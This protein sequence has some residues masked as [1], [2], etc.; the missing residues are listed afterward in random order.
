[1]G[2]GSMAS[3]KY[4]F[5]AVCSTGKNFVYKVYDP[6]SNRI[7]KLVDHELDPVVHFYVSKDE[8]DTYLTSVPKDTTDRI[9]CRYSELDATVC[10]ETGRGPRFRKLQDNRTGFRQLKKFVHDNP[11]VHLADFD[12]ADYKL[13]AFKRD[14]RD[15]FQR[16]PLTKLFFDI[17]VDVSEYEG[18]PDEQVAPCEVNFISLVDRDSMTLDLFVLLD[19]TNESMLNFIDEHRGDNA[20]R[21]WNKENNQWIR[22][23][24]GEFTSQRYPNLKIQNFNIYW[25]KRE[26]TAIKDFFKKVHSY[27]FDIIGAWNAVFDIQ[28]L[29]TRLANVYDIDPKEL[30]CPDSFPKRN[31]GFYLRRDEFSNDIQDVCHTFEIEGFGTW[32]DMTY[33]YANIRK[34]SGKKDSYKLDDVLLE[35][36]GEG[37]FEFEGDFKTAAKL[38]FEAFLKY[39]AF[40]S[41]RLM[42]LEE[43]TKDMD[44][45][46][47]MALLT[48][49][50]VT[51]ALRPTISIRNMLAEFYDDNGLTLSNNRNM[52]IEHPPF[53]FTGGFVAHATKV[54]PVGMDINGSKSDTMFEDT[55]DKDFSRLYPTNISVFQIGDATLV[56]KIIIEDNPLLADRIGSL[57]NEWDTVRVGNELF[58]LPSFEEILLL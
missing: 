27:E 17:E 31:K 21:T 10:E 44:T 45:V 36:I 7:K 42:E 58:N 28:T 3:E 50:R 40:D 43:K 15:S 11:N 57:I 18:F 51:K 33:N 9:E 4:K 37:K 29:A 52:L 25:A 46:F 2:R 35:E 1:M 32:Q 53:A 12:L 38:N 39:S 22:D 56:G 47:D 49:T 34:G 5:Q 20:T 55:V 16:L 24:I 14:H 41:F 13:A 8:V 48:N 23:N 30:F 26:L 6:E 54:L 19:D